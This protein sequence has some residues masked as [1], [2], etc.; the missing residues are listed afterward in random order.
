MTDRRAGALRLVLADDEPLVLDG[1]RVILDAQADLE[2]AAVAADGV[3]A[4]TLARELRPD[5]LLVDLHMPGLDGADVARRVAAELPA[6]RTLVLTTFA[7]DEHV[8]R[9]LAAGAHG[10]VLKR[11]TPA[12]L[13]H[14]VRLVAGGGTLVLPEGYRARL[15]AAAAPATQHAAALERLTERERE[16]LVLLARGRTNAEIAAEL[17][18]GRE[19][20]KTHVSAVLTKLGARDRT[21]AVVIAYES[22]FA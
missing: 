13:V 20:V 15:A 21:Q 18:L 9:A 5:V 16:V 3:Q 17:F 19:T 2:V 10:Y 1:L 8:A 7:G 11:S 6:I 22:G 12:E 4:L 14:A